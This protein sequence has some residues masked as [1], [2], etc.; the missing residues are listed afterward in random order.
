MSRQKIIALVTY[1]IMLI[2]VVANPGTTMANVIVWVFVGLAVVHVL[3]FIMMFGLLRSAGGSMFNHF[4]QTLLYGFV[5]WK[6][7]QSRG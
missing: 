2:L 4:V 3:E 6:P 1:A 5:H 7:L